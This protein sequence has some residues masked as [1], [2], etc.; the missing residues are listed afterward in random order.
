MIVGIGTDALEVARVRRDLRREDDVLRAA[1]TP[2]EI[3]YCERMRHPARHYAARFAAKEAFVKALGTGFGAGIGWRDV[4]VRHDAAGAPAL[5]LH[6]AARRMAA[7]RRVTRVWVSL[8]H[9]A[10][11]ATATVVIER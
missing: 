1:F 6:G 3:E 9:T 10:S 11:L 2:R 5:V 8:S 7:R 4:E